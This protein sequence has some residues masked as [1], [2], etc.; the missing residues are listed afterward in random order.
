MVTRA[1]SIKQC[2]LATRIRLFCVLTVSGPAKKRFAFSETRGQNKWMKA[3]VVRRAAGRRCNGG[4]RALL[5]CIWPAQHEIIC[6]EL[7][8]NLVC[9]SSGAHRGSFGRKTQFDTNQLCYV[10]S[11]YLEQLFSDIASLIVMIGWFSA[12]ISSHIAWKTSFFD[13][14]LSSVKLEWTQYSMSPFFVDAACSSVG[15]CVSSYQQ[16]L[17]T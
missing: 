12:L 16:A 2:V 3:G 7:L 5:P 6:S 10:V 9:G 8:V 1:E 4:A 13:S 17:R 11:F 15:S 14:C